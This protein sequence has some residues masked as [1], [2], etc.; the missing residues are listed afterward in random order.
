MT[1]NVASQLKGG[2]LC[3]GMCAFFDHS[4]GATGMTTFTIT[5]SNLTTYWAGGFTCVAN[6]DIPPRAITTSK[7]RFGSWTEVVR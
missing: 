5:K 6:A 4:G 2:Q 1:L 3:G 7:V